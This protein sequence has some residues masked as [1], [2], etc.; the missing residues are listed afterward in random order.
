MEGRRGIVRQWRALAWIVLKVAALGW[1]L[2]YAGLTRS[3]V[4]YKA[5]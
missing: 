4:V 1:F 2:A 3:E 5:F